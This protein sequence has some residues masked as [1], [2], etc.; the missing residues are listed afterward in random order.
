[1]VHGYRVP[2]LSI[3]LSV[4]HFVVFF[5]RKM[6]PSCLLLASWYAS[7][8][9]TAVSRTVPHHPLPLQRPSQ[10]HLLPT[11]LPIYYTTQSKLA[12]QTTPIGVCKCLSHVTMIAICCKQNLVPSYSALLPHTPTSRPVA[13]LSCESSQRREKKNPY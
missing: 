9:C 12:L 7:S 1:M 3:P 8:S 2:V 5:L 6:G 13:P 10:T 11:H 4:Y